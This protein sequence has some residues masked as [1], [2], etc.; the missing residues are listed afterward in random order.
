[1]LRLGL[2]LLLLG[3]LSREWGARTW[4]FVLGEGILTR[5]LLEEPPL[6]AV[7][8]LNNNFLPPLS[9]LWLMSGM[10]WVCKKKLSYPTHWTSLIPFPLSH[11]FLPLVI[12]L[13]R[14]SGSHL[15]FG[16]WSLCSFPLP[17]HQGWRE[18]A[19]FLECLVFWSL[20]SGVL[21]FVV[22]SASTKAIL[23]FLVFFRPHPPFPVLFL[24]HFAVPKWCFPLPKWFWWHF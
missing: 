12:P 7:L 21:F 11:T 2:F 5:G 17:C 9:F 23:K 14:M 10:S 3:Y 19:E 8:E 22:C 16:P 15:D 4:G 18:K 6:M 13:S 24:S 1:M 20:R